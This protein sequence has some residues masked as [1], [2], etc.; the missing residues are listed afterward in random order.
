MGIPIGLLKLLV[1][2]IF[3]PAKSKERYSIALRAAT[4]FVSRDI[5]INSSSGI[6]LIFC[7]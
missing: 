7:S 2:K 6:S 4:K 1:F 5:V 3:F